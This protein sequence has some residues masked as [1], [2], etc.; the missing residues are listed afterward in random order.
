MPTSYTLDADAVRR[1]ADA[2]R[3]VETLNRN[4]ARPQRRRHVAA[5]QGSPFKRVRFALSQALTSQTVV[6]GCAVLQDWFNNAGATSVDVH[7]E[8]GWQSD[9]GSEGLA[10]WNPA[11]SAWVIILLPCPAGTS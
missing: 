1:T 2:V 4:A 9:A 5:A 7:N 3:Y 6:P 10:D 11:E 8:D